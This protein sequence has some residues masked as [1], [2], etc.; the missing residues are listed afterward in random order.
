MSYRDETESLR[1]QVK[2]L[3]QERADLIRELGDM[4]GRAEKAESA[5]SALK[6]RNRV[7]SLAP[8]GVGLTAVSFA[9][10]L[11]IGLVVMGIRSCEA[12][13]PASAHGI[14]TDTYHHEAYTTTECRPVGKIVVCTPVYHPETWRVRVA[15]DG[16]ERVD[17]VTEAEYM[18][19]SVGDPR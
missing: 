6:V 5:T 10:F 3:A 18:A 7:E 1:A 13:L 8:M 19:I 16:H 2:T 12:E 9:A 11:A 4:E 14:V 15:H 17:S